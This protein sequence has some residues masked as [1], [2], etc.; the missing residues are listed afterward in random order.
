MDPADIVRTS[1]KG[2]ATPDQVAESLIRDHELE[3][4]P[5]IRALRNGGDMKLGE[6]KQIVHRNLPLERQEAAEELWNKMMEAAVRISDTE[7]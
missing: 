3:P 6:A 4:I 5:A 2:G 1:L 7:G